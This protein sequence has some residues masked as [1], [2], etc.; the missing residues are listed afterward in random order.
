MAP[1]GSP[2]V[3]RLAGP[4][5]PSW[6]TL[7]PAQGAIKVRSPVAPP[8][9]HT[10]IALHVVKGHIKKAQGPRA[11]PSHTQAERIPP[12]DPGAAARQ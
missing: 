3:T 7:T 8:P 9:T 2:I 10:H 5:G 4:A 6:T 11:L 12:K 1:K